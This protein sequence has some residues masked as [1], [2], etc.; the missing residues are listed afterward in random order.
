MITLAQRA[1]FLAFLGSAVVLLPAC[2]SN[3]NVKSEKAAETVL[4]PETTPV[5]P[6]NSDMGTVG[7]K[8][9]APLNAYTENIKR[10]KNGKD[11]KITLTPGTPAA[12]PETT[13]AS[14]PIAAPVMDVTVPPAAKSGGSHWI[15]WV[16]LV[17]VLG[18]VGWFLKNRSE[19]GDY[20]QPNPPVGGLSPVS[21]FTGVKNNIEDE[22][23]S[24]TSFWSKKLF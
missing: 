22:T 7:E 19:S 10:S 5:A 1:I 6:A 3:Q 24:K 18:G 2:G 11:T 15:W 16:L 23:D 4:S 17:L 12:T 9:N 20:S 14:T 13:P 21:G 8:N